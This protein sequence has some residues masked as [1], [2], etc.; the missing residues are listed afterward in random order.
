MR[1]FLKGGAEK[2]YRKKKKILS[3]GLSFNIQQLMST[4][5]PS[6]NT[7]RKPIFCNQ[8]YGSSSFHNSGKSP[9]HWRAPSIRRNELLSLNFKK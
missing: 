7:P 1:S 8:S 6:K 2:S 4:L 5:A 9:N 3:Y